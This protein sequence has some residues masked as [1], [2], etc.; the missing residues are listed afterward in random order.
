MVRSVS[1]MMRRQK[2]MLTFYRLDVAIWLQKIVVSD[3]DQLVISTNSV[4]LF[5]KLWK[6]SLLISNN[7]LC[8]KFS[9]FLAYCYPP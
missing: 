7:V 6:L 2:L 5:I 3:S 4:M 1:L 8:N 9:E